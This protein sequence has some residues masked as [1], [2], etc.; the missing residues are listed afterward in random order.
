MSENKLRKFKLIDEEGY[1]DYASI[2][3]TLLEIYLKDN[4]FEGFVDDSCITLSSK[5]LRGALITRSEFQFFEEVFEESI[6]QE[7]NTFPKIGDQVK[8]SGSNNPYEVVGVHG[9]KCMILSERGDYFLVDV[10]EVVQYVPLTEDEVTTR[11]EVKSLIQRYTLD[12]AL[13][14]LMEEYTVVKKD[15]SK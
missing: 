14:Y 4:C 13:A 3:A 2:N 11:R 8:F 12:T 6:S 15:H 5:D 9:S 10:T 7:E 1:K